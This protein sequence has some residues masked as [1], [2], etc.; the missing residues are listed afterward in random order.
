ME[1]VISIIIPTYRNHE[2]I[3]SEVKG[4][5]DALSQKREGLELII[6]DDGSP[7]WEKAKSSAEAIG[8]I[9]T[10]NNKNQGK[11][12]AITRGVE[13]ASGD[14]ILFTDADVPFAYQTVLTMIEK[15]ESGCV[16]VIGDRNLPESS[17][18]EEQSV[19]RR[20]ASRL[21]TKIVSRF[22]SNEHRDTQCGLKGF[23]AKLAKE[24]FAALKTNGFAFDLE[25]ISRAQQRGVA[26]SKMPVQERKTN[27]KK[28]SSVRI[29]IHGPQ[30]LLES[31]RIKRI[32][33]RDRVKSS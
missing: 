8:A 14:I 30:M 3:L 1:R 6:V 28:K 17:Y 29:W 9:F 22:F 16:F 4:F 18:N 33:R 11:G 13:R 7:E 21:F 27:S 15:L 20:F 31:F 26:I 24:L 2:F 10:R 12:A 5:F 32:L 19:M 25:I 23:E